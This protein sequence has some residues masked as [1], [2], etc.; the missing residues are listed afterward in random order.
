METTTEWAI[1]IT[2]V[3]VTSSGLSC[4]Y[5]AVETITDAVAT[6]WAA[7]ANLYP[8]ITKVKF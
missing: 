3:D 7:A 5:A 1:A 4:S 8:E 2:D 6:S